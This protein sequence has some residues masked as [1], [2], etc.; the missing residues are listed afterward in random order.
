MGETK[1]TLPLSKRLTAKDVVS[2]QS[3]AG[4]LS[5]MGV[6]VE[7]VCAA[8]KNLL[9]FEYDSETYK[10]NAGRKRKHIPDESVLSN[11][12]QEQMDEWLL[13]NSIETIKSELQVGRATAFRRRAEARERIS[14]A[15]VSL[16]EEKE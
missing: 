4:D 2:I 9:V 16:G 8:G 10:R 11:M 3:L 15:V 1:V 6:D 7:L 13:G 5:A 14:Y 12:S